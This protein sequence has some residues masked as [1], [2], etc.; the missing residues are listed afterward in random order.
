MPGDCLKYRIEGPRW[1]T[2]T[3]L[4]RT[5]CCAVDDEVTGTEQEK[6]Q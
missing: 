1:N 2:Q 5:N 3:N 6:K 4:D